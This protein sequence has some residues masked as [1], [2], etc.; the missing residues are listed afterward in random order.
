MGGLTM[1][2][3]VSDTECNEAQKNIKEGLAPAGMQGKIE[4]KGKKVTGVGK[5]AIKIVKRE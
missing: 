4:C 1:T 2:K 5:A 3:C